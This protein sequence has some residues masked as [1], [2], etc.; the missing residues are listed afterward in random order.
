M[1]SYFGAITGDFLMFRNSILCIL[2]GIKCIAG[3]ATAGAVLGAIFVG[4]L[5]LLFGD[6]IPTRDDAPTA[7]VIVIGG[8]A[9]GGAFHG[10]DAL[11]E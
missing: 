4:A 10:W 7:L 11:R 3:G 5:C 2:T 8:F 9:L 6:E 1:P